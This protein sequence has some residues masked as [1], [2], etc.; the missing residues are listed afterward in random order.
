MR[1]FKDKCDNCGIF[2]YLKG[3][4]DKCL[5]LKC[6]N[7]CL[8]GKKDNNIE[9]ISKYNQKQLNIFDFDIK[10]SHFSQ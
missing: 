9:N 2:D 1:K 6:Q 8:N 3:I 10:V 7:L 5:C 4:N